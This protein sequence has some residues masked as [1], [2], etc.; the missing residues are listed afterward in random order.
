[1]RPTCGRIG[2]ASVRHCSGKPEIHID[3]GFKG[4]GSDAASGTAV[5]LYQSSSFLRM[6]KLHCK[7]PTTWPLHLSAT[8]LPALS[9]GFPIVV[10]RSPMWLLQV[11]MFQSHL[12]NLWANYF[13]YISATENQ[14]Q[15]REFKRTKIGAM[16][17]SV[18]KIPY[19][20]F[21]PTYVARLNSN[22]AHS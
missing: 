16:G 4:S 3:C 13:H 2:L 21:E 6:C 17:R 14:R 19:L 22:S 9:R 8:C 7:V 11:T 15:I 10:F 12:D 20:N 1:L 5:I 18:S